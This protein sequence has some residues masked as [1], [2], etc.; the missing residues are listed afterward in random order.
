MSFLFTSLLTIGL[1]LI[2]LPLLIHLINLRRHKRIEWAAMDFLLQS[3]KKNKKW[4]FLKQLLLLLLRTAAI[5]AVVFMVAQPIL[6]SQWGQM[7]GGATTHHVIL[8]DDSYSM[9]E[10]ID[11]T[12]PFDL[13]KSVVQQIAERADKEGGEQFF[14]VLRFSEA[15]RLTAGSQPD[16][17]RQRVDLS[18]KNK[19][20]TALGPRKPFGNGRRANPSTR[21]T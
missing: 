3:Q 11:G 7:L 6:K 12:T 5:A 19:L 10:S 8:L 18:F 9:G 17:F 15:A 4:V 21:C 20:E 16:L 13:S 2:A 14:T 1:P